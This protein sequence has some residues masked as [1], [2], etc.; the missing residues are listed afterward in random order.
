MV[1]PLGDATVHH[2]IQAI[3]LDKMAGACN[4]MFG[5]EVGYL[6][7]LVYLVYLVCRIEDRLQ[8]ILSYSETIQ[9]VCLKSFSTD[10]D[11]RPTEEIS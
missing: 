6:V 1:F 9:R 2:D 3:G 10:Q 8:I 7:H 11:I 4:V 5:A